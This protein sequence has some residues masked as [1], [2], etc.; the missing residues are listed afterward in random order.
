MFNSKD[1]EQSKTCETAG[2]CLLIVFQLILIVMIGY[3]MKVI[4]ELR[5]DKKAD[6]QEKKVDL[7]TAQMK[8]LARLAQSMNQE[9][10]H[11]VASMQLAEKAMS[12]NEPE[13]ASI[14]LLNAINRAPSEMKCLEA[15]N[16]LLH[17]QQASEEEWR[18]F[19]GMLDLAVY[20]VAP[21]NIPRVVQLKSEVM[22][23]LD[24]F[25]QTTQETHDQ[26]QQA[27]KAQRLEEVTS[28]RLSWDAA[29]TST[30]T[31]T[32]RLEVLQWL[33]EEGGL[34][35]DEI[36]AWKEELAKGNLLLQMNVILSQVDNA[37][38]KAEQEA[39]TSNDKE[40]LIIAQNQLQMANALLAQIWTAD[41]RQIPSVLAQA[42]A[43]SKKIMEIDYLLRKN[44]SCVAV[45]E[46]E[47][48]F[49]ACSN[50]KGT[51]GTISKKI[52]QINRHIEIINEKLPLVTDEQ[53]Q[54]R[55][56]HKR[57]LV[58]QDLEKLNKER[59]ERYQKWALQRLRE[60]H[61]KF[62]DLTYVSDNDAWGLFKGC[63]FD[64]NPALLNSDMNSLY[65]SV[66]Q[67]IY[68]KLSNK[69]Q[70]QILKA[71]HTCKSLEDF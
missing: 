19:M 14:Y 31:L 4:D 23:K 32:Q 20:Q 60:C 10:D 58:V 39:K 69:A 18:R 26:T 53:E 47:Q 5:H 68:G 30:E 2:K 33:L 46:I 42:K 54:R 12:D 29:L 51:N 37:M 71:Q 70:A 52:R 43:M 6:I 9:M 7:E 67:E 45:S 59:Y 21:S 16:E 63:L 44:G 24:G 65:N 61:R 15:Y 64:I 49:N 50:V 28:G 17:K 11:V 40:N 38:E 36:G 22:Q 41:C 3:Q 56:L 13:L 8:S 35:E 25:S 66:Y 57:K 1:A 48:L 55:I 62:D 27:L 34:K